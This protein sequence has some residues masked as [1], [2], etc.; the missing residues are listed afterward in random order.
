VWGDEDTDC[1]CSTRSEPGIDA[2]RGL[3]V[4]WIEER[5]A[6][7][8]EEGG[9]VASLRVTE[10][11][12]EVTSSLEEAISGLER[13]MPL[14]AVLIDLRAALHALDETTGGQADDAILDRIFA[15]FC[16]GK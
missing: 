4:A 1:V 12:E 10:R 11:L 6:G 7:D 13:G 2:L 8:A 16:V 15:T 9:I 3:L 14:E 5:L